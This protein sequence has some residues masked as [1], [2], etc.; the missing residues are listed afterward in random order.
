[1]AYVIGKENETF[2]SM[3]KKFKKR[4]ESDNIIPEIKRRMF[5]EK[6]S[7]KDKRKRAMAWRRRLK[8]M[9]KNQD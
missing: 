3:L 8:K 9:N 5:Y 4:M 7:E 2:D 1:M 6:P